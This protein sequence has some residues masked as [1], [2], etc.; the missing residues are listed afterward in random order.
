M[1]ESH[2]KG[3]PNAERDFSFVGDHFRPNK[4][5]KLEALKVRVIKVATAGGLVGNDGKAFCKLLKPC[6]LVAN[7][8]NLDWLDNMKWKKKQQG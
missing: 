6:G 5:V 8:A 1:Q 3:C 2:G 7:V 4:N